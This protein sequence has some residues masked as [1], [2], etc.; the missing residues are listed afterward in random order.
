[1]HIHN[2]CAVPNRLS[3]TAPYSIHVEVCIRQT[4]LVIEIDSSIVTVV[5]LGPFHKG[6]IGSSEVVQGFFTEAQRKMATQKPVVTYKLEN[7]AADV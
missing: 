5:N 2:H 3:G 4:I 1:M 6:E 7:F